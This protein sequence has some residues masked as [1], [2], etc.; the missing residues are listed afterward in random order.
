MKIKTWQIGA[1][2][3]FLFSSISMVLI[4]LGAGHG[5]IPLIQ[6]IIQF[7]LPTSFWARL[8][9]WLPSPLPIIIMIVLWSLIGAICGKIFEVIK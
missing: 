1:V 4:G 8:Y 6:K 9:F 3:G 5:E 2:I 7:G